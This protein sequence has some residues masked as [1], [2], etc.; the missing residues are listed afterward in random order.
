M[1]IKITRFALSAMLLTFCLPVEAQQAKKVSR[2]AILTAGPVSV[3]ANMFEAFKSGLREL[4]YV[5]GQN[6]ALEIQSAEGRPDRLPTLATELVSHNVDVIVT[7]TTPA[8]QAAK[9]ATGTIPIVTISGDPVGTGL[10]ASLARPG[11]NITGL[12]LIGPEIGGKQL[13]ILKETFSNLK[14]VAFIRDP[15]NAA[16]NL[17]FKE[18]EIAARGLGLEVQSAEV[19]ISNEVEKSL[20]SAIKKGAGALLIAPPM[21]YAHRKEI[22]DFATKKR[23][24]TMYEEK[25]SVDRGG[26]M[27]YGANLSD[28]WRRAATYVDKILKG[29]KPADLPIERPTKFELVI[30]LKTANQLGV[31]IPHSVLYRADRVIRLGER[32]DNGRG[33][34]EA[35][36]TA[37]DEERMENAL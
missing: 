11:S 1:R 28:L 13:E 16:L 8:I 35:Q 17:R 10:V 4:G 27:S 2:V 12:S 33:N 30:N 32:S 23:L 26:L 9:Q 37:V 5:E 22:M 36:H 31:T 24:P 19:R 20:E 14:R 6:I 15:T 3:R 18:A 25:E 7:S 34:D 29:T 21:A